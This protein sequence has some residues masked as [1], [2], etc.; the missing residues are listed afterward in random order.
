MS[1]FAIAGLCLLCWLNG[2]YF[3]WL[4]WRLPILVKAK[5]KEKN[6]IKGDAA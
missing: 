5:R 6:G 2:V 1:D 3:G 4:V